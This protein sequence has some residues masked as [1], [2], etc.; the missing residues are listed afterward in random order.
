MKINFVGGR[1][2][3]GRV[4]KPV[5]EAAGHE[6]Y[7]TGRNSKVTP[8]DAAKM[9]D[10]TIIS[11]P[12]RYTRET[13]ERVA[14]YAQAIMD[15]TGIKTFPL[16]AMLKYAKPDAEVGGLHPAY[17]EVGSIDGR[18]VYYCPTERSGERCRAVVSAFRKAG[19]EII[20][21]S[22]EEHD[23]VY[24]G[25]G[26]YARIILLEAYMKFLQ[27]NEIRLDNFYRNSTPPTA[28]LLKLVARQVDEDKDDLY[29]DMRSFNPFAKQIGRGL[30]RCLRDVLRNGM[31]P[32]EVRKMFGKA[33][34]D[35]AQKSCARI[36]N[37]GS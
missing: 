26:Q 25:I 22:P 35:L 13:I 7:V 20:E 28:T 29:Q 10:M 21:I 18:N 36:I 12:I 34:L 32:K 1:G 33:A 30:S 15:L 14:P 37:R 11:V 16:E 31:S 5:F 4:H 24:A 3:M 19:A 23:F 2:E 9:C 17:G 27:R 6:V 8:I